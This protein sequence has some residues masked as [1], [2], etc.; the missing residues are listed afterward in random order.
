M[1]L[2]IDALLRAHSFMRV[3]RPPSL[4]EAD[5]D[6]WPEVLALEHLTGPRDRRF[7]ARS[8]PVHG[9]VTLFDVPEFQARE[10]RSRDVRRWEASD[11][12]MGIEQSV[13]TILL[14][15]QYDMAIWPQ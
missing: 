2:K 10:A 8:A 4:W 15:I 3:E 12:R 5:A 7:W 9:P 1:R 14:G 13:A 6:E 11:E